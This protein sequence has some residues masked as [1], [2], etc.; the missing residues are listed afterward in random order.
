MYVCLHISPWSIRIPLSWFEYGKE[1]MEMLFS[2]AVSK[3]Q[4]KWIINWTLRKTQPW[5]LQMLRSVGISS[6]QLIT[7]IYEIEIISLSRIN[8]FKIWDENICQVTFGSFPLKP[9]AI[10]AGIME[11]QAARIFLFIF[12]LIILLQTSVCML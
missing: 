8:F 2:L 4:G 11:N 12:P 7:P 1:M 3:F 5:L 6:F 10:I 9:K